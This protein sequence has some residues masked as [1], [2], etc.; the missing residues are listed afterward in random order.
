VDFGAG[1]AETYIKY[2]IAQMHD[3]VERLDDETVNR[4][5][6]PRT[7]SVAA[8]VVHCCGVGEFWL[9]HVGLGRASNRDRDSEFAVTERRAELHARLDAAAD[10]IVADVQA[11]DRGEASPTNAGG[12]QLLQDGDGTDAS[13]VVHV[14]EELY[15]H[16]GHMQVTADALLGSG[17]VEES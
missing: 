9:G 14:I 10:G 5:P 13:L 3:V 6:F 2:A 16:L 1:T 12:R 17:P 7:N 8:L 4:A 11:L 15:Q